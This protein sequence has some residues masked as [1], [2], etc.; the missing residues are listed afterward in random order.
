[1]TRSRLLTLCLALTTVAGLAAW[2]L[3]TATRLR[4]PAPDAGMAA[5]LP[6]GALL[7]IESPDFAALLRDWNAS[8]EQRAWLASDN[9]SVFSNSRLFGRLNDARTE[10]EGAAASPKSNQPL[11]FDA[12]FLASIAGHRSIFAWYD[13]GNLEFVYVTHLASGQAARIALLQSRAAFTPRRIGQQTFYMRRG[14]GSEQG[15]ART[16]AFAEV[17]RPGDT[18]LVLATREDLIANTLR[19]LTPPASSASPSSLAAEPWYTDASAA[20]TSSA[21]NSAP[22]L[23]MVLN[24]DRIV[25]TPYFRSYWIQRNITQMKQYRAAVADLYREPDQFREERALLPKDSASAPAASATEPA[26]ETLAALAPQTGVFRATRTGDPAVAFT[27]LE[28]KLLSRLPVSASAATDAPDPSLNPAE[29]G[30]ANDL[31]TSIDTRSSTVPA[32]STHAALAQ[33]LASAGLNAVMTY[34]SASLPATPDSLWIPIHSA[35]L[36]R[37]AQAWNPQTM[38]SALQQSLRGTLTT[39]TLGIDFHAETVASHTL[40]SLAGPKP[41]LFALTSSPTLG[42]L[43]LL[44]DDRALLLALL[45]QPA[46]TPPDSP[47]AAPAVY[48]AGFD[49][50]SQRASY[51]R[52]TGLMDG[53]RRSQNLSSRFLSGN[54]PDPA[55]TP[56]DETGSAGT[57]PFFS[58]NLRSLSD[59]FAT[60]AGQRITERCDGLL[61]RQTVLYRWQSSSPGT[62]ARSSAQATFRR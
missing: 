18:L 29:S 53:P 42:Q 60:L 6:P 15:Q 59:S 46:P 54:P 51:A 27:A 49:H 38:Q 34:S 12:D 10:F 56:T 28:D 20:L 17:S 30:S 9:Y 25:A 36:L 55:G 24:L 7:T 3:Q 26:L 62:A 48:V 57:P 32:G 52:L 13:I 8:P 5:L 58:A 16:V 33:V 37:A 21:P 39:S 11:S 44:S 50:I 45:D 1:M 31:E 43:C 4:R 35:V 41:L 19:L 22:A 23:R 2:G 40:Y 61:I 14:S 47:S